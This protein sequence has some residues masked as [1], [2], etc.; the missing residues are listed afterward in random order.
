MANRKKNI[1]RKNNS[2]FFRFLILLA[3]ILFVLF[4]IYAIYIGPH[5]SIQNN[6]QF[7]WNKISR[8][9]S[10]YLEK[11]NPKAIESHTLSIE[12]I[13][14][15]YP[16]FL[17]SM[18]VEVYTGFH[19]CYN[20]SKEQAAWVAYI[21]EKND[22]I[23]GK[24]ER[25][26]DFREDPNIATGSASLCD[27]KNSGFDRG[28]LVPAGDM[29]WSEK[30]MSES[31]Y[32]SNISPQKPAFNRGI[33]KKLEEKTRYWAVEEEKI[34]VLSGPVFTTKSQY[35]GDNKVAVPSHYFKV[36]LDISPPEFKGIGFI[37]SHQASNN[38]LSSFAV[39]IDE[40]EA[41]TS[42]DFFYMVKDPLIEKIESQIN[43]CEWD[44]CK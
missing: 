36:I 24:I 16:Q 3:L 32:L 20:E 42:Y 7:A 41:F 8:Q 10:D 37:L 29:K 13:E 4:I 31:F 38:D 14:Q 11:S 34:F 40:V 28:H 25:S 21:L 39:T 19:L 26:N 15:G 17:S 2:G 6:M 35:I 12:K 9:V 18:E 5:K 23:S 30:A 43:I 27:Y 44:L 33:W 22:I 1:K